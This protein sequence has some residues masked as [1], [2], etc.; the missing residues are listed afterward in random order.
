MA[1]IANS[2]I[3]SSLVRVGLS[4]LAFLIFGVIYKLLLRY[5]GKRLFGKE[6]I[7]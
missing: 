1:V 5:L 2:G 3:K 4:V 7:E 6:I